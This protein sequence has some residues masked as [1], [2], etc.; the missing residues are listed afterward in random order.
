MTENVRKVQRR[1]PKRVLS[2]GAGVQSTALLLLACQ[3]RIEPWDV[4]VFA[5]TGG[6][7]S[8]VYE[9]LDKLTEYAAQF[10][11][12]VVKV[13]NGDL[14]QDTLTKKSVSP[15]LWMKRSDGKPGGPG[16]RGCTDRYKVRPIDKWLRQYAD[17]PNGCTKTMV[18][19]GIGISTD[20]SIRMKDSRQPWIHHTF[21]LIDLGWSRDDCQ[22]YLNEL[23]WGTTPKSACTYCPYHSDELWAEV[24]ALDPR[25]WDEAIEF[26]KKVRLGTR[27]RDE[28]GVTFFLHRSYQPLDQVELPEYVPGAVGEGVGCSPFACVGDEIAA[29]PTWEEEQA[30]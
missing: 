23:G 3:R 5:D 26:D 10:D 19:L 30:S 29:Q 4:A 25:G 9:H 17:V 18:N 21:P 12:Q 8:Y 20:E 11:Q 22:A 24:K 13:S 27:Q 28:G 1:K 2:L 6:E 15:P 7:P 16:F 14:L